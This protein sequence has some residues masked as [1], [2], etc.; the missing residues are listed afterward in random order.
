MNGSPRVAI[1]A[2]V[3]TADQ[4]PESQL[5]E[6]RAYVERR[7]WTAAEE[8]VDHG[9]SGAKERRPA[10]DRLLRAARQR[11]VDAILVWALDRFGRSLRHLVTVIDELGA[12][13]VGFVAFTQGIDTTTS[14]PAG[15]LT[16]QVLGA[17][18]EFER[19]MI[20]ERVRAGIAKARAMGTA[21]GRPRKEVSPGQ[22]RR[23][24]EQG[25]SLREIG[26]HLGVSKNLVA[27]VLAEPACPKTPA[28]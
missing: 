25:L 14:N 10:L 4:D 12:L 7:G 20:R 23:L 22:V 18:A 2:R 17:V 3:S 13:G 19:A 26:Q 21:L 6:L 27:R 5:R 9:V 11:K 1:Y 28:A 8:Y 16:L 24:R 15:R